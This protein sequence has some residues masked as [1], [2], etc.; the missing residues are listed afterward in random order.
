VPE[1]ILERA[2]D[3][4]KRAA[5]PEAADLYAEVEASG[6][7]PEDLEAHADAL[8]WTNRVPEALDLRQRAY[9]AYV[10]AGNP[11]RAGYTAWMM[12]FDYAFRGDSAPSNGWYA[13]ARSE[14]AAAPD[15]P[16]QAVVLLSEGHE[17]FVGGD[18]VGATTATEQAR[19]I[20]RRHDDHSV[21]AMATQMLGRFLIAGGR[22]SEGMALIDE[23]MTSV[24]SGLVNPFFT[25]FIYCSVLAECWN[26]ADFRRAGEWTDAATKWCSTL[27]GEYAYNGV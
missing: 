27:S 16:E 4:A 14:L 22:L 24:I 25:G 15:C 18:L 6:L 19:E 17:A 2:R 23:A 12:H 26:I 3:A 10:K 13:R 5:W 8:W 21:V 20:A 7:T 11:I 1:D 9:A